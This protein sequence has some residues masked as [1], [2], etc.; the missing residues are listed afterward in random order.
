MEHIHWETLV[1]RETDST[2]RWWAVNLAIAA[3]H[4]QRFAKKRGQFIGLSCFLT[5]W[6]RPGVLV[7]RGYRSAWGLS[8]TAACL[9]EVAHQSLNWWVVE[10]GLLLLVVAGNYFGFGA[11]N[12]CGVAACISLGG[13]DSLWRWS[14]RLSDVCL[15][16]SQWAWS[17]ADDLTL[18][19]QIIDLG[20]ILGIRGHRSA[21]FA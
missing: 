21:N 3:G 11:H 9:L 1:A 15:S 10:S 5:S 6:C 19:C 13:W 17:R 7:F 8:W 20:C 2:A 4:R 16:H 14:L 18:S 12:I